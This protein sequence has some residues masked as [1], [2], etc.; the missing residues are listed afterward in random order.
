MQLF[1]IW[2]LL[3]VTLY[4]VIQWLKWHHSTNV[5]LCAVASG[6]VY[7]WKI[8]SGECKMLPGHAVA[9]DCGV[10]MPD[11]KFIICVHFEF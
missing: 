9:S 4:F 3:R 10:F 7:M 5:L 1:N 8:P 2:Y 6:E 11:G